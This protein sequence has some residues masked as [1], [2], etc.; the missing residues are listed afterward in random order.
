M[1]GL[2]RLPRRSVIAAVPACL[3]A[4]RAAAW[5]APR[6]PTSGSQ[7]VLRVE[8]QISEAAAASLATALRRTPGCL[9]VDVFRGEGQEVAMF[10]RWRTRDE[11]D[12]FWSGRTNAGGLAY[13]NRLEI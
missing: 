3:L 7:P 13:L 4:L 1:A 12:A 6:A 11:G 5:G 2:L 10:Q 9:R 8:T